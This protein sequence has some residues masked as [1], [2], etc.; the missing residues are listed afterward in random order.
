MIISTRGYVKQEMESGVSKR[1]T[2]AVDIISV[3][4]RAARFT[5][6]IYL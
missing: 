5:M 4:A 2:C 3:L 1:R 6:Y